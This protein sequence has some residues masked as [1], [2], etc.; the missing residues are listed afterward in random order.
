MV[1]TGS[2]LSPG[3]IN[4]AHPSAPFLD[5]LLEFLMASGC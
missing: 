4:L 2:E 5:E 1:R 3:E